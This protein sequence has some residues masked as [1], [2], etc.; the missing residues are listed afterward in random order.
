MKLK[1][2]GF[3]TYLLLIM[4]LT[5]IGSRDDYG[6]YGGPEVLPPPDIE[7]TPIKVDP[8]VFIPRDTTPYKG[9]WVDISTH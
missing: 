7:L 8:K 6:L 1:K 5:Y 3:G 9:N 2:P 4:G